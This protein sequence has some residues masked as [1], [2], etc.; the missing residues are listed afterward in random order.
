MRIR[1]SQ[2]SRWSAHRSL[3]SLLLLAALALLPAGMRLSAQSFAIIRG[4][5]ATGEG[6]PVVGAL[7]ELSGTANAT[8]SAVGGRFTLTRV[9]HGTQVLRIRAFGYA[10]VE[11]TI[12]VQGDQTLAIVMTPQSIS[13]SEIVVT[14]VSR[15]PERI[16]EA[17]AAVTTVEPR[18]LQNTAATG[19]APLA[20]AR[21]P[22]VDLVQAGV[23][24]FNVNARGFNSSLN[25]R[26][27]TMLDGRDLAIAF[28]GAQEWNSLPTATDAL[29]S[30]ELV[31]GPGS[32]L[33]GANA[34]AGVINM[35]SYSP[36]EAPGGMLSVAGGELSTFKVDGRWAQTLAE[37]RWGLRVTGGY[38]RNDTWTRSRTA[39]DGLDMRRE[40][41]DAVGAADGYT[42]ATG[43]E[44]VPLNGQTLTPITRVAA[45]DRTPITA[46]FGS[47]RLDN[48][49]V[50]DGI[51]T[52]EGGASRVENEVLVTGIGRVQVIEGFKPYA[53]VAWTSDRFTLFSYWN[54][55][56][57]KQP[58]VSLASGAPLIERSN[59]YHVEGQ[60]NTG[61]FDGRGRLVL[62]A[63]ERIT[64]VDTE[65]TLMRPEDDV[66]NDKIH[67]AYG[68]LDLRLT[69]RLRVVGAARWDQG[70]LFDG[71]FSPKAAIVFS[72]NAQ[73]AFR[74]T[75]N[76]AFQT[77]NYSEFY[78]RA[79]AAGNQNFSALETGLRASALGPVL[80]GV[81][82]GELFTSSA[83]VP[84]YAR[85]NK[86]LTVETTVGYE[87]GYRGSPTERTWVTVDAYMNNITN[88]VTDLLPGVNPNFAYWTAPAQVPAQY[89]EALINAVRQNLGP[90]SAMAA[91]GLTRTEDGR[92]AVVVSYT[93]AGDV[94]QKGID[95]GAGI[96]LTDRISVDGSLSFF[97]FT[98]N[99][100]QAGDQLVPNTPKRKGVINVAYE[101]GTLDASLSLRMVQ[102]HDWAAGV[103]VGRIPSQETLNGSIGYAIGDRHRVSLTG[104]NLFDQQ[105]YSL[106]GGSVNGRRVLAGV[107]T[108]F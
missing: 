15:E 26:V 24:D 53:R 92:T 83:A 102:S 79:N 107:S 82:E 64:K 104:T 55:R 46:L 74:A 78:L 3:L 13:L 25:R 84:V 61:L 95:I 68:Q 89:H 81:P 51:I 6:V 5:V 77:P 98:V 63:S 48:Y 37:G 65:G 35:I 34:F 29:K 75:V 87:I 86:D 20:L 56:D 32:A 67:S 91:G 21:M 49:T 57:S 106:Y 73:H 19:Q 42:V 90:I 9:P 72:P 105:R 27:L 97:S 71:Q 88:F 38:G 14:A 96:Q 41:A 16:V 17:P 69:D 70:D 30:M 103:F 7:I 4:T 52:L 60:M 2:S 36:R 54:G 99:S 43:M 31:R 66:R 47:V 101:T 44:A 50:G 12:T 45:G 80:A 18:V 22:G 40:Y 10:P 28:L 85:G 93:N 39:A 59:I 62:G 33:Y 76:R 11:Q 1:W 8:T 58:Q 100:Q 23:N 108:R 94:D